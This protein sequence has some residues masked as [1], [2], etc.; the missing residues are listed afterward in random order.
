ML[1]GSSGERAPPG[2]IKKE[3]L[4]YQRLEQ[5]DLTGG[6]RGKLQANCE[7]WFVFVC[8]LIVFVAGHVPLIVHGFLSVSRCMTHKS[9]SQMPPPEGATKTRTGQTHIPLRGC[10]IGD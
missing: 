6:C 7:Q 10:E 5:A 3:M 2:A 8:V 4:K 1:G 9:M